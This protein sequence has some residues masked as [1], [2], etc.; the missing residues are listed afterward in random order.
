MAIYVLGILVS[1]LDVVSLSGSTNAIW[2]VCNNCFMPSKCSCD[3]ERYG[4]VSFQLTCGVRCSSPV[5]HHGIRKASAS[6]PH[7]HHI[8]QCVQYIIYMVMM[9]DIRKNRQISFQ[10]AHVWAK[11]IHCA[12]SRCAAYLMRHAASCNQMAFFF[13]SFFNFFAIEKPVV[14]FIMQRVHYCTTQKR[15]VHR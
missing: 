14:Y 3:E 4:I 6:T 15:L 10:C 13:Y 8:T 2:C 7:T 11:V 12:L 9:C 5:F 1:S